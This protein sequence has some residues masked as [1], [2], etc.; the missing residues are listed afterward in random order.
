MVSRR[1]KRP[2]RED[3]EVVSYTIT[4]GNGV[5]L[6]EAFTAPGGAYLALGELV[7]LEVEVNVFVDRIG[8]PR[9]RLRI[10]SHANEF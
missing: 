7:D 6:V 4:S 5:H 2:L 8:V 10:C 1:S 9:H 3:L